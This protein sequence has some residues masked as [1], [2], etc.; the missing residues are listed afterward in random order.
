MNKYFINKRK[1]LGKEISNSIVAYV[2]STHTDYP[3]SKDAL[4]R[5]EKFVQEGKF[6][7]GLLVMLFAGNNLDGVKVGAAVELVHTG[8]LIHDDIMDR[9]D[10]RRGLPTV[11]TQYKR[12]NTLNNPAEKLHYAESMAMCVGIV[13]YFIAVK[14]FSK[15]KNEKQRTDILT[16]FSDEFVRLGL[17]QMDDVHTATMSDQA[18]VES[19]LRVYEQKTGRYTFALPILAGLTLAGKNNPKTSKIVFQLAKYLGIVFQL[20]DD[21]L[22]VFGNSKLTGKSVGGDIRERKITWLYF[23]ALKSASPA[24]KKTLK[25]L[26]AKKTLLTKSEQ[27]AVLGIMKKYSVQKQAEDFIL[28]SHAKALK[29]AKQLPLDKNQHLIFEDLMKYLITRTK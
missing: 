5:L 11:H 8:I 10:M 20:Q 15:I 16:L 19:V 17:G 14:Q 28:D 3:W 7:R 1:I 25:S 12:M 6:I 29:L 9:D 18:T 27:Q 26:Y 22:G 24:D 13:A 4:T 23:A 2:K 21:V